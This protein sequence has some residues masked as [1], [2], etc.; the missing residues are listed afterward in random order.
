M[1]SARVS[2]SVTI[3]GLEEAKKKLAEL[4]PKK[5]R[6]AERASMRAAANVLAVEARK[7]APRDTGRLASAKGVTVKVSV[8]NQKIEAN[9]GTTRAGMWAEL[10]TR[11]H[12][13]KL[14]GKRRKGGPA[15]AMRLPDGHFVRG[16]IKHPGQPAR[17]FIRPALEAKKSEIVETYGEAFKRQIAKLTQGGGAHGRA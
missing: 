5:M 6:E 16:V 9:V 7:R 2:A 4:H 14:K 1:V 11:P 8:T 13:V 15:K 10:G 17:P 12:A 3:V